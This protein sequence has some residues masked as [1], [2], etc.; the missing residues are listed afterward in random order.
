MLDI[1]CQL[2]IMNNDI[3]GLT[4]TYEILFITSQLCIYI[5]SH[6]TSDECRVTSCLNKYG[7][8]F[9]FSCKILQI[10]HHFEGKLCYIIYNL[11]N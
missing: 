11:I 5:H 4:I 9:Y 1:S 2:I 3:V 8:L 10:K 6:L 7:T